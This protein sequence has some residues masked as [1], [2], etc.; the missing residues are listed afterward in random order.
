MGQGFTNPQQFKEFMTLYAGNEGKLSKDL[1][2]AVDAQG[3]EKAF[4]ML[5]FFTE[6]KDKTLAQRIYADI[7]TKN[8]KQFDKIG[9]AL[10]QL[11]AM[12]SKEINVEAFLGMKDAN[13][14]PIGAELLEKLANDLAIIE[15]LPDVTTKEAILKY[16]E[17]GAGKGMS[18]MDKAGLE[19]L[20]SKWKNWDKLPDVA[21]K[22]AISKYKTIYETV[23]AD[24]QARIDYAQRIAR[25]KANAGSDGGKQTYLYEF[26]YRSTYQTLMKGDANQQASNIAAAGSYG[27]VGESGVIDP[28]V[29]PGGGSGSGTG[30]KFD[31]YANLLK[32]L[33]EVRNAA[34]DASGGIKSLNKAL[35]EGNVTSV[36]NKYKGIEQQ[37]QGKG[38]NQGFIDFIQGMD[39]K[40]QAK[41]MRT[42][43]KATKGKYKGQVVNPF[44]KK[45]AAKGKP[46]FKAGQVFL[47]KDA[48]SMGSGFD[49]LVSGEFNT[50]AQRQIKSL[51]YQEDAYKK[52]RAAG[53]DHLTSQKIVSDEYLA[54]SISLG[55]ITT[56]EIA[57]NGV[58]AKEIVMR[59]KIN[60]LLQRGRDKINEQNVFLSTSEDK[61]SKVGELLNFFKS[62][63][64]NFGEGEIRNL[65]GDPE[66]LSTL[67]GAMD[68]VTANTAG[69]AEEMDRLLA[70]VKALQDNSDINIAIKIATQT[71]TETVNQGAEA[72]QRINSAFTGIYSNLTP[73]QLANVTSFNP[74]RKTTKN[75]GAQAVKNVGDRYIAAG[76]EIPKIDQIDPKTGK[77]DTKGFDS[78]DTVRSVQKERADLGKTISIAQSNANAAQQAY[79]SIMDSIRS[80]DEN[81]RKNIDGITERYKTQVGGLDEQNDKIDKA[82]EKIDDAQEIIDGFTEEEDKLNKNN[83]MYSND[84]ALIDNLS[85]DINKKYDKQVEALETVNKLNE[86]IAQSQQ[87]QLDLAD[88][89]SQ[90]DIAAAARAAQEMRA[91][92][93]ASQGDAMMQGLEKSR[94]NEL[95]SLVGPESGMTRLQ[96]E[97]EQFR[98]SQELYKLEIDPKRVQANKDIKDNTLLIKEAKKEIASLEEKMAAEIKKAEDAHKVIVDKLKTEADAAK[99]IADNAA[100]TV[101]SLQGQDTALASIEDYLTAVAAEAAALDESTGFTLEDYLAMIEKFPDL[102]KLA[103]DYKTAIVNGQ[104]ASANMNTDWESILKSITDLPKKIDIESILTIV[105]N[106]TRNITEYIT[107]VYN[108]AT[109]G[110]PGSG[111]GGDAYTAPEETAESEANAE[112]FDAAVAR[113]DAAKEALTAGSGSGQRADGEYEALLAEVAA[114]QAAYDAILNAGSS[115][116]S[117][118]GG[119]GSN[120]MQFESRGG[121]I[122]PM[123]FAMGGFA[124]GTDTVPAMLTPGEFI[125]SKY[126][127]QSHG[128]DTMK[129]I[130]SGKPAGGAVY[131]N[132]YELTVNAK[133]DANPNEIAQAVMSTIKQVDD[134]RIRGVSLNAR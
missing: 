94:Q 91:T 55:K 83:A 8:P 52:L 60:G 15:D 29:P 36:K 117:G 124:K 111:S 56:E 26:I 32:R 25:E 30:T 35:A 104:V 27:Y 69:A 57:K 75:T 39:P 61:V 74:I 80:A 85:D 31:P 43:S 87:Q 88:A 103:E 28:V 125:M 7:I 100:A 121:L 132:T 77:V 53:Y 68:E 112:A 86:Q 9:K 97:K 24:E 59:E 76:V 113:L 133:T 89:L 129:A 49:A 98:I 42:A 34:I 84:L 33:K 3:P 58:L 106:V 107:T 99:T 38:Y 1:Q 131:N 72:A 82:Q 73:S 13:G 134:R 115:G 71:M 19:S 101:T 40:E 95:G 114:A 16:F 5:N 51:K 127:V 48:Q 4:E 12:D 123:K 44:S 66:T 64:I 118:G 17:Q 93:A 50:Q 108:T 2:I 70:G 102:V 92:S 116:P 81:L 120:S 14:K 20:M 109:G 21:K 130:N 105:E 54:Q 37:L 10:A 18:G 79:N 6:F 22:E 45:P 90:G 126:A 46:A 78:A 47:S 41:F 65:L 119:G 23:F 110:N 63:N 62:K 122:N 96:I 67:I 11:Q 128:I